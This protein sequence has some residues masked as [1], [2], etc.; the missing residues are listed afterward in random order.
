MRIW[1]EMDPNVEGSTVAFCIRL[2]NL[3]PTMPLSEP[4]TLFLSRISNCRRENSDYRGQSQVSE[5][6]S[7]TPQRTY[8]QHRVRR[9]SFEG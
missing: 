2:R 8:P 5:S 1:P 6:K 4:K 3:I 9:L 7:L